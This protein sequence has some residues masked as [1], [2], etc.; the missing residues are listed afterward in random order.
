MAFTKTQ[1]DTTVDQEYNGTPVTSHDAWD[2]LAASLIGRRL[3]SVAG[4][5]DYDFD[6]NAIAMAQNGDIANANDRVIWNNQKPHGVCDDCVFHSHIHWEQAFD[7]VMSPEFTLEYRIQNNGGIKTT[8]WTQVVVTSAPANEAFD[9]P[10]G[11]GEIVNQITELAL[12]DTS[13]APLSSTVQF[14]LTRSDSVGG[15][16]LATFVDSHVNYD[17]RGSRQEYVK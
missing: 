15:S 13:T 6:E 14:R 5:I 4:T 17:Q 12:V 11:T 7:G 2:D 9:R 1:V 3:T 10:A 8:A 16:V